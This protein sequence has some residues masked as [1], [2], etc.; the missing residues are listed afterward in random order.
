MS[1]T[2]ISPKKGGEDAAKREKPTLDERF[3]TNIKG[4]EF[5]LYAGLLDLAHQKGIHKLVVEAIQYPTKENRMEAICKAVVESTDGQVFTE[6]ADANPLNVNRMVAE[7]ILRVAATRAKAR[8]FRDFT[9]IGMTC[10]EELGNLDD[11]IGRASCRE[12]V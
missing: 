8:V 4:K 10:L 1:V 5:V 9:N 7:H 11:E 12:R 3:I 2:D 6:L